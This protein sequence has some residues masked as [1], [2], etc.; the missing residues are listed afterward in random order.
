ML[1]RAAMSPTRPARLATA[2]SESP[3]SPPSARAASGTNGAREAEFRRFLQPRRSLR[4]RPD[5]A[6]QR[7]LA[8]IDRIGGQRR[9]GKRGDERGGGGEIGGRLVD[10]QAAGDVEIDVV[11]GRAARR[12][13]LRAPRAPSTAGSDPSRPRRGAACRAR[14]ARPAPGFRPAAAACPRCRRTPRCR[15]MPRSRSARN[16]S[17]GLATSRRPSPVISNTPISS[18][19]PKRFF[20]ARR[21]RNWCAAF[22]LEREHRVDHVLDH[23]GAGDLAVLGDVADEDDGGA[24]ASWRSGSAPAPSRAPA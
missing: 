6:G 11:A 1:P 13:G 17:D 12:N 24:G 19:G 23:A 16:S 20:T 5:R 2:L 3:Q 9:V 15:A 14:S 22:A 8:E 4:H 10:A 7:D 18:V 21:M